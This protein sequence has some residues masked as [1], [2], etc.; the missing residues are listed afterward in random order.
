MSSER[1]R[2]HWRGASLALLAAA[3]VFSPAGA[4]LSRGGPSPAV[5]SDAGDAS[6]GGD[7]QALSFATDVF[8]LLAPCATCHVTGRHAGATTHKQPPAPHATYPAIILQLAT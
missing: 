7:A 2:S 6:D 3:V 8:P 1:G 5:V 4:D